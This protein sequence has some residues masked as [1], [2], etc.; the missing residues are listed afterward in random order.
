M[1]MKRDFS[2]SR[3]FT[4]ALREL[5]H[6]FFMAFRNVTRQKRRSAIGIAAVAFGII[7]L[8]EAGG[9]IQWALFAMREGTIESRYG[10]LQIVRDHYYDSGFSDPFAYLLPAESPE[11]EQIQKTPGVI[12]ITPRINFTGLV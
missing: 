4:S 11:F 2:A 5:L 1:S 6:D 3:R 8:I 12:V 10:H 9:F 7:A